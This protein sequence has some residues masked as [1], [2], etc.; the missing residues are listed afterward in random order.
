MSTLIDIKNLCVGFKANQKK[1]NVVKSISFNIPKVKTV[2]LVGESGSGK[3]VTALSILKL[4]PYVLTQATRNNAIKDNSADYEFGADVKYS[5][6]PALTL[7]LTYNTDF[8]QV[9]VDQ[10]QVNLDRF[11]F[12]LL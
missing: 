7:D 4:L 11:T 3:T 1:Q 9:E 10:Q 12:C 8:A 6:T 5:I 2:A